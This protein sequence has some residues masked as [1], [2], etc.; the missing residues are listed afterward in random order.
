[1]V[2]VTDLIAVLEGEVE[3]GELLLRNLA[4]QK[5]AILAWDSAALLAQVEEKEHLV[6]QLAKMEE[7]R[8]DTVRRLLQAH[9]LSETNGAS[10]L[11]TLLTRLP[12]TAQKTA[13]DHLQQRAWQIYNRLRAGEKHLTNLMGI[14]LN[15]ISE[16]LGSLTPPA[17]ITL[18][19][20][21]G[22]LAAPRPEPGFVQE[23]I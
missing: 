18:Y 23:K 15:H 16:A 17:R 3:L 9:G 14:L 13:L 2:T 11:K 4:S 12:L 10:A 21:T 22:A 8:R 19:G 1:M 6:R 20:G 5:E 7:K